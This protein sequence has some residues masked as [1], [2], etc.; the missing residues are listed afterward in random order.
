MHPADCPQW[1]YEEVPNYTTSLKN[2]IQK[3]LVQLRSGKLETSVH[4]QDTRSIHEYFF[5]KLT[6]ARYPYFAGHYRGENFRCLQ[7]YRVRVKSDPRVGT[8]PH[9]VGSMM[10]QLEKEIR[11]GFAA[12]DLANKQPNAKLPV[13]KKILYATMFACRV[14]VAFLEIHPYANGNGHLG[15]FAIWGI[16]GRYGYWPEQWPIDPRPDPPYL[17]AIIEH[18]N[19]NPAPLEQYVLRCIVG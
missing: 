3:T 2:Q 17:Q 9:A 6:P 4:V 11:E 14:L 1:D 7:F 15:R 10:V 18:R 5:D 19:G 13:A 8:L 16:L 12:L